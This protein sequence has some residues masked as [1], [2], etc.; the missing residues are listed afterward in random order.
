ME[1][2]E[3]PL[4]TLEEP[5]VVVPAPGEGP[6]NW[7][8]AASAVM[9]DG[10]TYLAYRVR[11]PLPDGRGVATVVVRSADGIEFAPVCEVYR[12]E[13]GAESTNIVK[14]LYHAAW[15]GSRLGMAV[16]KP[17]SPL[18]A[19]HGPRRP[20]HRPSSLANPNAGLVATLRLDRSD[21]FEELAQ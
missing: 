7:A 5:H 20:T 14:P 4:P 19:S 2:L 3:T 12:D 15:L 17:L 13:F 9:V 8:G 21:V 10:V 11:R 6:G 18:T 1:L 16:V